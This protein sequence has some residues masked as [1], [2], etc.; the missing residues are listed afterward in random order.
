MHFFNFK[1]QVYKS[2]SGYYPGF[3]QASSIISFEF[4][5]TD[6]NLDFEVQKEKVETLF[7]KFIE[8]LNR[9]YYKFGFDKQDQFV[10]FLELPLLIMKESG[11]PIY[12]DPLIIS[13]IKKNQYVFL[14]P[15]IQNSHIAIKKIFEY[16]DKVLNTIQNADDDFLELITKEFN[17]LLEQIKHSAPTGINT[18]RFL[19]AANQMGVPWIK[20]Y[21]NVYQFGWGKNKRWLDSSFTDQTSNIAAGLVRNKIHTYFVL[22][23]AGIPVPRGFVVKNKNELIRASQVLGFPLAVKPANLDRGVGV[24]AGLKS[25]EQLIKAFDHAKIFSKAILVQEHV[26]GKDYRIQVFNNEAYWAIERQPCGIIGDGKR[27]INQLI[28][29]EN[30]TRGP[31]KANDILIKIEINEETIDLLNE[32]GFDLNSVPLAGKFIQLKRIANVSSGGIPIP[33]LEKAHQDNLNLAIDAVKIAGLDIAGVDLICED[34]SISW[35][36]SKS[37]ICEINGQPQIAKHLPA[38]LLNK[39][40]KNKGRIPVIAFYGQINNLD[41]FRG[42]M[43]DYFPNYGWASFDELN[44]PTISSCRIIKKTLYQNAMTL[45]LDPSVECILLN[46]QLNLSPIELPVDHIDALF[47]GAYEEEKSEYSIS[48]LNALLNIVDQYVDLNNMYKS[49]N[50]T[51]KIHLNLESE[52]DVRQFLNA[53]K[54]KHIS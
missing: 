20:L 14:F 52:K 1:Y 46:I 25:Q 49:K 19:S 54:S 7:N 2:L 44:M 28:D 13:R 9:G 33:V 51:K 5:M 39:I 40:V 10:N 27:S 32:N 37:V 50:T 43:K 15:S 36:K 26:N 34:I 11:Y 35:K 8:S 12:S 38:F 41:R 42:L 21:G 29:F 16:S 17:T 6:S 18:L 3:K 48:V 4:E 30:A 23:L 31:G 22:D 24:R 47:I 45:I 53:L